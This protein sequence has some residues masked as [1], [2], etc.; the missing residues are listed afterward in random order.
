MFNWL[1]LTEKSNKLYWLFILE[2]LKLRIKSGCSVKSYSKQVNNSFNCHRY[3]YINIVWN[4]TFPS[5]FDNCK[6][7]INWWKIYHGLMQF[8]LNKIS[9]EHW[10]KTVVTPNYIHFNKL[11]IPKCSIFILS[12]LQ[13][14]RPNM[15]HWD[16][17]HFLPSE[18]YLLVPSF[19][20]LFF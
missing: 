4:F 6:K 20:Q 8:L 17:K 10:K 19:Y 18:I 1:K 3:I 11:S 13:L 7:T 9:I 15:F 16:L 2:H 12:Y 5:L 14:I